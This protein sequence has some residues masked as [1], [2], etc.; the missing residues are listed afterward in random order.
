MSLSREKPDLQKKL[1]DVPHQPGVYV[2]RD[3]LNRPI[4]VGK[5]RDLRKRLSSYFV[6]SNVRRADLKT[7]ALIDSIWD[8]ETHLVR[9][10]AESLLLEGRLIKDFRPRYNISF[11][12]DKRF[13]LVK[14]QMADPFPRFVLSRLKK[15]DGARYFGPFAHSGALRTTLNWMNKQFGLRVCRPMSPNENDYRHCS[16]DIIKNCAAPCIGRVTPEEYRARVEQACDF[17]GGK[18][19]DLVTA[20]EEEMRKAAE[21]LDFERAAELRDMIEDFKKTLKPT[22]SFERGARA[23]VVSTLDPMA[24]V[25]ELQEYLRLDRPPLVMECFDIA[26]IGTAHC[27]ASMVRFKNGVPDNANYRRYRIR[28]VSGQNDFAAMSEVVRRRYSRILLEGRERMGAEGADLSQEDPLEAMRRLEEEAALADGDI[29]AGDE[30]TG[31]EGDTP[32]DV[33]SESYLSSDAPESSSSSKSKSTSKGKSSHKTQFVRLPDLVII[34]GGKGQLSCAMEELQRLG[35]HE[36]PVI[37]LAKEEEEIY[38][39]GI[40]QPLRI[41]H[42]RGALKLLQRIRDEAHRWANGY[43]QLLLRRRVEESILDDCPGVSQTRKANIL[44]V[45]GSVARLR[46][47]TVEEV[48]KVPGIGKG[49]AEEIVRFLKEREG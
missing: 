41:P 23:K 8:F 10:E 44:R 24:D 31:N 40:D 27:V 43:H 32:S 46:R 38:R 16:N 25:S 35:L 3:R 45:F 21:R 13:L 2:M 29:E 37:G 30:A 17:L 11:R 39:P 28:I 12:D 20:L 14:V 42:D 33:S 36:L 47:A 5:A 9:N 49:L 18:S 1:H 26:N 48:A 34:D 6:P 19:R 15:D 7:K 22:R 4:Y